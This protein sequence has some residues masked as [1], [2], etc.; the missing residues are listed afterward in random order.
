MGGFSR[1]IVSSSSAAATV[2]P[3]VQIVPATA[4]V[5]ARV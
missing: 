4:V 3:S 2:A 1:L 5:R